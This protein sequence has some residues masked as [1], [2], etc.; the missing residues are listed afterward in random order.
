MH[1]RDLPHLHPRP[2]LEWELR[3]THPPE[4]EGVGV[5]CF[6]R[7]CMCLSVGSCVYPLVFVYLPLRVSDLGKHLK[8]PNGAYL[9]SNY[10]RWVPL[11]I[12]KGIEATVLSSKSIRLRLGKLNAVVHE[13][14]PASA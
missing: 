10:G 8:R 13:S 11:V 2:F 7:W 4:G 14:T 6:L 3:T 12:Y 9:K 5:G 1:S